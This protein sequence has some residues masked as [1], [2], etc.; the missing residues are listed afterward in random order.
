MFLPNSNYNYILSTPFFLAP[1]NVPT[2]DKDAMYQE[3]LNEV[4][5]YSSMYKPKDYKKPKTRH[6]REDWELVDDFREM[7]ATAED[8][9]RVSFKFLSEVL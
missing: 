3:V 1:V 2:D 9:E 8:K 6:T 4:F 5:D 7:M